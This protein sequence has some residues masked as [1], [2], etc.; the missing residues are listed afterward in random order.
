M[1]KYL[2]TVLSQ[3]FTPRIPLLNGLCLMVLS[4]ALRGETASIPRIGLCALGLALVL[5]GGAEFVP[6]HA[7]TAIRL[8]RG[9]AY[10]S[11]LLG[12]LLAMLLWLGM[13]L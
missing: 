8:M 7:S 1:R 5:L 11:T 2:S 10:L 12:C 9:T 6:H 3:R 4:L 13:Y